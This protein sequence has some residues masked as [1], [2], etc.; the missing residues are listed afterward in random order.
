MAERRAGMLPAL[1]VP[2][3]VPS[4]APDERDPDLVLL[5]NAYTIIFGLQGDVHAPIVNLIG[6]EDRVDK[7]IAMTMYAIFKLGYVVRME[8]G[9]PEPVPP[10]DTGPGRVG[11]VSTN[12]RHVLIPRLFRTAM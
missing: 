2:A 5:D 4:G 12:G 3:R 8:G 11:A 6:T 1:T 9:F 10:P 7:S